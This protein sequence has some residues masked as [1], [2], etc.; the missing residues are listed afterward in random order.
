MFE[1]YDS[2]SSYMGIVAAGVCRVKGRRHD[3]LALTSLE[4]LERYIFVRDL[5]GQGL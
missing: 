2:A 3:V 4:I 1:R 5:R